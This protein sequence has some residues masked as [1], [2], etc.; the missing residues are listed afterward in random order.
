[1]LF[2]G[3][4]RLEAA[5]D[6]GVVVLDKTGT[7]TEGRPALSEVV[8]AADG[9][10]DTAVRE[11]ELL[12]LAASLERSSEHPL[13]AAILAGARARDVAL[14]DAEEFSMQSGRGVTGRV[15]GRRVALGNR[16]LLAELDIDASALDAAA[17]V[18]AERAQTPVY[19]AIDGRVAG[20]LLVA[21][22][23]KA[24]SAAAVRELR[25]AGLEVHLLTGDDARTARAVAAQVGIEHVIAQV[26]PAEKAAVIRR[27][28]Q[29]T[30][31]RV[32][33]VGDGINDAPALAQADVGI[34]IGTG[35]DVA[36][37]ASDITL[38]GGDL[39][40]V[41]TA[42]RVSRATM[43]V[44]RQNLFWAFF[45]NVLGIPLA[46][47][48]L[49]PFFGVLLSPVVA[50]AAMALSSVSVVSNSLRLRTII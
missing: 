33:M 25:A 30:G 43:R 32:A 9:A 24:G 49:Y 13:G 6:I 44:I 12:R 20:L 1:V 38:V 47:G 29:E 4:D 46:A 21:D 35:T 14:T 17:A 34:A 48:V 8:L 5:R 15:D 50:S 11:H 39:Q 36:L 3:G 10:A 31:R 42:M 45:Y 22:R 23:V 26:L 18:A 37:E 41:V 28:Q 16:A 19:A 7:V 2:R 40:G 27:L